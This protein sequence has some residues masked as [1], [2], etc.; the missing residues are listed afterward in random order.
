M[1]LCAYC[2]KDEKS[3]HIAVLLYSNT[4]A[5]ADYFSTM[6]KLHA[7]SSIVVCV[8]LSSTCV[9][10]RRT[11][12]CVCSCAA[13]F[14][15]ERR[16]AQSARVTTARKLSSVTFC[17]WVV[18]HLHVACVPCD[19]MRV[20]KLNDREK[21]YA[22]NRTYSHLLRIH[23]TSALT[24]VRA[25]RVVVPLLNGGAQVSNSALRV[26]VMYI[27]TFSSILLCT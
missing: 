17:F 24:A 4:A 21:R 2:I 9:R 25:K 23:W 22:H 16:A 10:Y 27:G 3:R 18:L 14:E 12:Y 19:A 26:L 15:V 5:C 7:V 20:K 8:M 1:R 11:P 13:R 6:R